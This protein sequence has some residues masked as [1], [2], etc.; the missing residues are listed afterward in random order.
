MARRGEIY[1]VAPETAFEYKLYKS[2][3][4]YEYINVVHSPSECL[5]M[6]L[7]VIGG[8]ERARTI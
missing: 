5:F 8:S 1:G 2:S 3:S 7:T 6:G 4:T